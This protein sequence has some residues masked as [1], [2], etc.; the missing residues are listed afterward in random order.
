MDGYHVWRLRH[1]DKALEH[2]YKATEIDPFYDRAYFYI[3]NI[4]DEKG[5]VERPYIITISYKA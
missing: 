2:Y 4:Y 5:I 3:A 1:L